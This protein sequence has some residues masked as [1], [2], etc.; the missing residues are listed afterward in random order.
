MFTVLWPL[1]SMERLRIHAWLFHHIDGNGTNNAAH[2]LEYVTRSENTRYSLANRTAKRAGSKAVK[3]RPLGATAWQMF[4]SRKQAA[5]AVGVSVWSVSKCCNG[6]LR[7]CRGHEFQFVKDADLPEEIWREAV[8]PKTRSAL[9]G[10]R[11]SSC[12]RVEGPTGIRTYGTDCQGYRRIRCRGRWIR[13]H[14]IMACT[15][16]EVPALHSIPW[17]V[18]HL[19]GNKSNNSI[20]NL[21]VVTPSDNSLHAWQMRAS[22]NVISKRMPVEG[23]HILTGAKCF[24]GSVTE[25]AQHVSQATHESRI[26]GMCCISACCKG[27]KQS[28]RGYEWRYS[29]ASDAQDRPDEVWKDV[30]IPGLLAAWN[31]S[32]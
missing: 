23:R 25:A 2:N 22:R 27:K 9:P 5:E 26:R 29:L 4:S 13:V 1:P 3:A 14:R 30:H 16:L 20:K 17:E 24:F 10:Y 18:N 21:E 19:D 11:I 32:S 15:F 31:A 8:H 28:F 12:G 7:S 6:K